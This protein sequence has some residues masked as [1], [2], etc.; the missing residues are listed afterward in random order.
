MTVT[1]TIEVKIDLAGAIA[2]ETGIPKERVAEYLADEIMKFL[3]GD[4]NE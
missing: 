2:E 3:Y 4:I 1:K